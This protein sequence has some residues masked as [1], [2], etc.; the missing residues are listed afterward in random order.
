MPWAREAEGRDQAAQLAGRGGLL[1]VLDD[2]DPFRIFAEQF[3]GPAALAALGIV[4][5]RDIRRHKALFHM[6]G[7][8]STAWI[9][10]ILI[11]VG[12]ADLA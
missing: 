2:R 3:E 9:V 7:A 5:E 11:E 1:Q 8:G 4:V 10:K 12:I 6:D